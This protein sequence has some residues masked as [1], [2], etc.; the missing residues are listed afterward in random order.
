VPRWAGG[1]PLSA[2][3]WDKNIIFVVRTNNET[4]IFT[5]IL[6]RMKG[7][8]PSTFCMAS[9]RKRSRPFAAVR[10]TSLFAEDFVG[11]RSNV[12]APERTTSVTIVTTRRI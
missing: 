8:E 3:F 10:L 1:K 5:G 12:N 9:V 7:L 2:R 11:A 6:E 4:S